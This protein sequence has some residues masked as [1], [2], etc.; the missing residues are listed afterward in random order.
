M[1]IFIFYTANV[2]SDGSFQNF[3]YK[4]NYTLLKFIELERT[5]QLQ[6]VK[7]LKSVLLYSCTSAKDI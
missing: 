1:S 2:I 6:R 3:N 7:K 5:D 4:S